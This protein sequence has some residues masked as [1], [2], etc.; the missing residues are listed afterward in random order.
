MKILRQTVASFWARV[1]RGD[2]CWEWQGGCDGNG[3]GMA[4]WHGKDY[5]AHRVAA[6]LAGIVSS[7]AGSRY[8]GTTM[9]VLHRCDNPKC[10]R[11]D[12]FFLG[13]QA[14]NQRDAYR[15]GRKLHPIPRKLTNLQATQIRARYAAGELQYPLAR[16]Y[17]VS[18]A[19]ISQLLRGRSYK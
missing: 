9:H 7:P 6:W 2:G 15:K 8:H 10:C 4:S 19:S 12:H 11:P 18:Q 17:G 1:Q 13:T 14:D 16:E 5:R 3:Y